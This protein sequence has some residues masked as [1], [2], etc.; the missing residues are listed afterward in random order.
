MQTYTGMVAALLLLAGAVLEE[1]AVRWRAA[2]EDAKRAVADAIAEAVAASEEWR[3]FLMDARVVY[4]LGRGPSLAS[5]HEGALLFNEAEQFCRIV[6]S[7]VPAL[8]GGSG[9]RA[10]HTSCPR[11][12]VWRRHPRW[13]ACITRTG[14]S[15]CAD[16]KLRRRPKRNSRDRPNAPAWVARIFPKSEL[17]AEP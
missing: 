16:Q 10:L 2:L 11:D 17:L 14:R 7:A 9:G 6:G 1:P 4:L 3:E 13:A 15:G 8:S 12:A 5:V